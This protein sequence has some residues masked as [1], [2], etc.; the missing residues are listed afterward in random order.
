MKYLSLLFFLAVSFLPAHSATL[1]GTV[2]DSRGAAIACA[3]P[4]NESDFPEARSLDSLRLV[5][6]PLILWNSPSEWLGY[7]AR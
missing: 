6:Y 1:L 3:Y 7:M 4:G 2:A 5:D